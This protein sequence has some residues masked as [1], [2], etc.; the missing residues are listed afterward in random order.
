MKPAKRANLFSA[1]QRFEKARPDTPWPDPVQQVDTFLSAAEATALSVYRK[2]GLPTKAGRYYQEGGWGPWLSAE[3]N[4]VPQGTKE[5]RFPHLVHNHP[6]DSEVGFAYAVLRQV[7]QMR[8]ALAG[9]RYSAHDAIAQTVILHRNLVA[10]TFE[11]GFG[12]DL[13]AGRKVREAARTGGQQK[14]AQNREVKARHALW[15]AEA[16]RYRQKHPSA[17]AREVAT[18]V[19]KVCGAEMETVRKIIS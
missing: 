1:E 8:P 13:S 15:R 2:H 11:F 10:L 18:H 5:F 16:E 14:A 9:G 12:G 6:R 3:D 7:E 19:A 17:S 4:V